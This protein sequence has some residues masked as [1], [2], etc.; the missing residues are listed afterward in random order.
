MKITNII[1]SLLMVLI[2]F[3]SCDK[4]DPGP[5]YFYKFK[6]NGIEKEFKG[7]KDAN[8]VFIEDPNSSNRFTIYTFVTGNDPSKNAVVIS[9]RTNVTPEYGVRYNMQNP[10]LVND[11]VA[12]TLSFV[13]FDE[14]GKEY[15][16]TLLQSNNPGAA[17]DGSL[18]M[19]E[20]TAEGS[21]GMFEATMFDLNYVGELSQRE[22]MY[23][24]EGEFFMPN[25]VSLR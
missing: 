19:T 4:E 25:F 24:T 17:D 8:I 13:Y 14:N 5:N 7:S 22:P 6:I 12:P 20:L 1:G 11:V 23:L 16:A 15:G 18:I 9:L 21:T 2:L 10:I 3:S